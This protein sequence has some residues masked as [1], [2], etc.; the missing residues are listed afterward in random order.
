MSNYFDNQKNWAWKVDGEQVSVFTD[1]GDHTHTLDLSKTTVGE[2]MDQPGKALG[3]A[4]RQ[5]SHDYKSAE[6]SGKDEAMDSFH[7]RIR[8][9]DATIRKTNQVSKSW[10]AQAAKAQKG[11]TNKDDGGR[12]RG[13]DGPGK[14]GR[15]SGNKV[16]SIRADMKATAKDS[17]QTV[18]SSASGKTIGGKSS[19]S[20]G[21]SGNSANPGSGHGVGSGK[22][23]IGHGGSSGG[24]GH[25]SGG[26]GAGAGSGG[27]GGGHGGGGHGG[28]SGGGHGGH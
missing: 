24:G 6:K 12:E 10:A 25:S 5:A 17:A 7:Q 1:H 21:K 4:H 23:A 15:E 8:V 9:D 3:D 14:Q 28:A 20:T 22:G 16:G 18:K 2:M 26:H 13:D 11:K 27:P 19:G